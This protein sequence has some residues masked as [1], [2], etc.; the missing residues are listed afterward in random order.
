MNIAKHAAPITQ[1]HR[2]DHIEY[3]CCLQL[4]LL[5]TNEGYVVQLEV[6]RKPNGSYEQKEVSRVLAAA[7]PITG[8]LGTEG[9][10]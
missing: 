5:S 9:G 7:D 6:N 3:V 1:D 8:V 4:I 10:E 2:F